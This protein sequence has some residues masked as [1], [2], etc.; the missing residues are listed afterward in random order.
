MSSIWVLF[1][2]GDVHIRFRSSFAFTLSILQ[3]CFPPF[4]SHFVSSFFPCL[5]TLPL[6]LLASARLFQLTS[7]GAVFSEWVEVALFILSQGFAPAINNNNNNNSH[8]GT[9]ISSSLALDGCRPAPPSSPLPALCTEL[10]LEDWVGTG[11]EG[12][13][14]TRSGVGVGVAGDAKGEGDL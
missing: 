9:M 5:S 10:D 3:G 2:G 4:P 11:E 13:G 1:L 12:R 8:Q 14:S 7:L 6:F